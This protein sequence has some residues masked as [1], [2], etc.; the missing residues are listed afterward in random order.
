MTDVNL[1]HLKRLHS[2]NISITTTTNYEL[3]TKCPMKMNNYDGRC[4]PIARDPYSK[5]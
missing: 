1:Y 3:I 5:H 2:V 4:Q